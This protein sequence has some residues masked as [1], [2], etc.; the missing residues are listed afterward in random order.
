MTAERC[1]RYCSLDEQQCE[2]LRYV[3]NHRPEQLLPHDVNCLLNTVDWLRKEIAGLRAAL[4]P[5]PIKPGWTS[6]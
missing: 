2:A 4:T 6:R 3:C 1:C 5:E